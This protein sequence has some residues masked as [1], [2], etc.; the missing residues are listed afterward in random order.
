[1]STAPATLLDLIPPAWRRAAIFGFDLLAVICA[2]FGGAALANNFSLDVTQRLDLALGLTLLLPMQAA[3]FRHAGLY[4]GIWIFSSLPD[5][6]RIA[7]AVAISGGLVVA[8]LW[9][10]HG[11]VELPSA[12]GLLYP[13]VLLLIMGGGRA[14]YRVWNER[15]VAAKRSGR[16]QPLL[17]IGA[18]RQA[19]SALQSLALSAEWRVIGILDDDPGHHR[20]EIHGIP[21]LGR[22]ADLADWQGRL[23]VEHV[24]LALDASEQQKRVLDAIAA[25]GVS[26]LTMPTLREW[27]SA[28]EDRRVS[29]D[30]LRPLDLGD[31]IGRDPVKVDFA[32][33]RGLLAGKP[34]LVTGA[35]GSIGSELCRQMLQVAPAQLIL[36]ENNEF[37]LYQIAEEM[38]RLAPDLD[39]VPLI[40][41][42]KDSA[43]VNEIM[44]RYS[45]AIVFHAAAYKHVPLMEEVNAWQAVR[46]NVLGTY[47]VA[48]AAIRAEVREFVLVS[49]DKA[50]NPTNVMGATKRMAEMV[51]LALQGSQSRTRFEI[52]RFGNVLGSAGS[53]IPKFKEQIERGGPVT[54]THPEITRYFMSIPEASQLV[55]QAAAMGDGGEIF[56]M[57]M[58]E[59][60]R[61][62]DLAADMI[63]LAGRRG[64]GVKIVYSGLRPGEKLFEEPLSA[65]EQLRPTPH[66]KLLIARAQPVDTAWLEEVLTWVREVKLRPDAEVRRDL[67]RWLSDYKPAALPELRPVVAKR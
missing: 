61:I 28:R 6:Q 19:A 32:E 34:I 24:L 18:G 56:V 57:D 10:S 39:I 51:C 65:N 23:K 31:L 42:V 2:W 25:T 5:L 30:S 20:R 11:Y 49:T 45:P 53:V 21:V 67:R 29:N 59:P 35:G 54:V 66:P 46:N 47:V 33:V 15:S 13:A 3:V 26:I 55:L 60:V 63:R 50:I 17:V 41:D 58:G 14:A 62:A 52:V 43:W 40:G 8:A 38:Q 22:I 1:V 44:R 9:I 12:L 64:E 48:Q 37:A 16:Q 36:F 4:R 27:H 7:R